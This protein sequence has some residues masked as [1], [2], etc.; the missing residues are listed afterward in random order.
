MV[1]GERIRLSAFS[2]RDSLPYARP[3]QNA[4]ALH[5]EAE[6]PTGEPIIREVCD[7]DGVLLI[8]V[9]NQTLY[10]AEKLLLGDDGLRFRDE[11]GRLD[12]ISLG[13]ILRAATTT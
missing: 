12:I 2:E 9:T 7:S 6:N 10:R 3:A 13:Q 5:V 4:V 1:G 11:G 8:L